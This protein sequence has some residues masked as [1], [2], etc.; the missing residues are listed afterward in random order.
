[1]PVLADVEIVWMPRELVLMSVLADV[2]IVWMPAELTV[3]PDLFV[4][5]LKMLMLIDEVFSDMFVEI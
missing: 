1:M 5:M 2:E 3:T 4:L